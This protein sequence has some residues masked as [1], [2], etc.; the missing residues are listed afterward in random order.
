[1]AIDVIGKKIKKGISLIM[2]S[3]ITLTK[4]N[5]KDIRK[6]IKLIENRETLLKGTTRKT[7]SEKGRF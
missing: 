6:V 1:M 5:I 2:G 4:N 3:R 7:T